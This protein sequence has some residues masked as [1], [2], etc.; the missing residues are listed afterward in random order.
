MQLKTMGDMN[1]IPTQ[2][3][4]IMKTLIGEKVVRNLDPS[5]LMVQV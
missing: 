1:F 3:T 5:I 2:M 4:V